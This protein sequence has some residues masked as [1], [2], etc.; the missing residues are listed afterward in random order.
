MTINE[1]EEIFKSNND[2]QK[3]SNGEQDSRIYSVH[4]FF[5]KGLNK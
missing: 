5:E 4:A 1:A 3:N 2:F